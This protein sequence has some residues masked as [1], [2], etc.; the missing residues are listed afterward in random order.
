MPGPRDPTDRLA[1][2]ATSSD[3]DPVTPAWVAELEIGPMPPETARRVLDALA[4]ES[5]S[6]GVPK[7]RVEVEPMGEG[8]LLLR[9]YAPTT[10]ALRACLN[11]HLRWFALALKVEEQARARAGPP[12]APGAPGHR[13]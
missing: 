9:A 11:A 8:R 2:R 12:A 7:T 13:P 5:G 1:D 10:S 4:P 6:D 3:A